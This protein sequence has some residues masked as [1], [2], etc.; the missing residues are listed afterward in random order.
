MLKIEKFITLDETTHK[1]AN[2]CDKFDVDDL[3]AIG[4]W[5][6]EGYDHDKRSRF[7]WEQRTSAAMDLALQMV[8]DKNFPWPNCSNVAFPLVT[9]AALQFHSRAY[10]ALVDAPN[11]VKCRVEGED[12]TGEIKAKIG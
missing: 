7:Q 4:E 11:I 8:R 6:W 10:P 5:A 2:L 12:P 9:I 3:K 1:S